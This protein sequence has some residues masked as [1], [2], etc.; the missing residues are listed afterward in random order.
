[1]TEEY[2][3]NFL[4]KEAEKHNTPEFKQSLDEYIAEKEKETLDVL[5]KIAKGDYEQD[6][7]EKDIEDT[8]LEI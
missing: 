2:I 3:R 5:L 6:F 8:S 1:M 7:D 4:Q